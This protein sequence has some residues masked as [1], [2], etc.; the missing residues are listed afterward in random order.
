[1][2]LRKAIVMPGNNDSRG[3]WLAGALSM[4]LSLTRRWTSKLARRMF[5]QPEEQN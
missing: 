5:A 4:D 2:D 1:M 3:A